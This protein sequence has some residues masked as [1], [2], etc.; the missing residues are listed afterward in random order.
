MQKLISISFLVIFGMITFQDLTFYT[1]FKLNQE[2]LTEKFCV[3]K[4]KK[5]MHCKAKCHYKKQVKKAKQEQEKSHTLT[6]R[7]EV[8]FIVSNYEFEFHN[9]KMYLI[10][11]AKSLSFPEDSYRFKMLRPPQIV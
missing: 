7:F 3:N 6:E 2:I 5:E 1:L 10:H 11:S 9:E 4:D 8:V